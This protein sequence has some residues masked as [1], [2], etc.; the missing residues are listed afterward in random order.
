LLWEISHV[1]SWKEFG[2]H[3]AGGRLHAS[4]VV[5]IGFAFCVGLRAQ[6]V[7]TNHPDAPLPME[8][9][10]VKLLDRPVLLSVSAAQ[11]IT[12]LPKLR[13]VMNTARA[14]ERLAMAKAGMPVETA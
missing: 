7:S 8:P 4:I 14:D 13:E 2:D 6:G 3:S 1:D 10:S 5:L 11:P 9:S 12:P